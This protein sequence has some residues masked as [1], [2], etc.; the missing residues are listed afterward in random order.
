MFSENH[1]L[2]MFIINNDHLEMNWCGLIHRPGPA[3]EI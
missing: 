2:L 3:I 1:L